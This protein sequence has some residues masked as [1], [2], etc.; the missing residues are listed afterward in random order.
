MRYSANHT[1]KLCNKSWKYKSNYVP[2]DVVDWWYNILFLFHVLK[3]HRK[4]FGFKNTIR[5]I[6]S[7]FVKF[8]YCILW[9]V[10]SILQIIFYP[11]YWLLEK[12]Y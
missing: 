7:I 12:L 1:C 6:W 10:V 9:I 5:A 3:E 2:S 11:F 8:L 4:E